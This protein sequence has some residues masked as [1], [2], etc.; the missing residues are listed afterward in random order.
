MFSRQPYVQE[1]ALHNHLEA[2][3]LASA[4]ADMLTCAAFRGRAVRRHTIWD[5]DSEFGPLHLG[6]SLHGPPH[7]FLIAAEHE[8]VHSAG[9]QASLLKLIAREGQ[10]EPSATGPF[11]LDL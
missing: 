11:R 4:G 7:S 3:V 10:E 1:G 5:L 6:H 8:D 9:L 2:A